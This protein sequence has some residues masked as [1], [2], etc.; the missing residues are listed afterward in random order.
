MV[1]GEMLLELWHQKSLLFEES[2][3]PPY[4]VRESGFGFD[5]GVLEG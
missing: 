1:V 3:N 2:S 4:D 5:L